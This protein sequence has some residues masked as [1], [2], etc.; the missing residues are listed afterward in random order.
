MAAIANRGGARATLAACFLYFDLSFMLWV[1]LGALGIPLAEAA[2]LGASQK[3]LVVA[4]PVL[5][6]SVL[7][8]P[9]GMLADR[10]GAKRVG[11]GMLAFLFLPLALGSQ[12]PASFAGLLA[13]GAMLGTAGSSFAVA[14]PLASR[15][16][17]PER[18]GLAMGI[19]AAGNRGTVVTHLV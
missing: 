19:A 7:R 14:L 11:M 8:I 9:M 1:L 15:W 6:G 4:L 3:G 5:T 12:L 2:H 16:F 10:L 18:Q 13:V 17:P